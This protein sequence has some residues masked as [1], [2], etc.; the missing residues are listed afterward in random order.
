VREYL[1]ELDRVKELML[2]CVHIEQGQPARGSEILTMRHR[3]GLL[4]DRNLYV[5]A[6]TM[7][8]VIRY[9]KS[10]SQYDALK[11]VPRFLPPRLG[12]IMA[13]YLSYLQPFKEYLVVQVLGGGVHDYIWGDLAGAWSTDRLTRV[14]K[15]ETGK[16]LGV[17]LHTL[18]YRHTAVG[19]GRVKVGETFGQGYQDE[20]GEINEAEVDEDQEDLI[21]LQ[22]SRTTIMGVGNYSVSIDI[23]KHLS[24][25]S[26]DAFRAL[27]TAW[28]RF[29]G[30]DGQTAA[31]E[32]PTP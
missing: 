29:L 27:S 13:L 19:I 2:G 8:S 20:V 23:V 14:L 11:V 24:T 32:E 26:I 1:R 18:A 17:E 10:Q 9:Y 5:I 31:Y 28:H 21:E 12:Q 3:N 25:R 15:R 7:V 4:Q 30:V 22:N 6:A 16:R